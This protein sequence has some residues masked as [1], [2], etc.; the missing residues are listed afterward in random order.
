MKKTFENWLVVSDVD[1]TLNNKFRKLQKDNLKAIQKFTDLGGHFTLA[2]GRFV[3]SLSKPYHQVPAN[4]P[5]VIINGSAIY[6]YNAKKTIWR[7]EI[8]EAGRHLTVE[9]MKKFPNIDVG[10]FFDDYLY[11][12]RDGIK[13]RFQM[14]F[15]HVESEVTDIDKVPE[16][17]WCKVVFWEYP[18]NLT[19]FIRYVKTELKDNTDV[20]FMQTSP[21]SFE[22]VEGGIHK[23]VGVMKLAEQLGIEPSHVAAIGD[24]YNDYDMLKTV[25]LAA[26][27]GQAPKAIQEL[28]Q[29]KACHCNKG[30]VADFLEYIMA[31]EE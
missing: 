7:Q 10:I 16:H 30:C 19:K 18:W 1:G 24:Y 15:D 6:D 17:G 26:C 14:H 22:M 29:Y 4:A 23:G 9:L 11:I 21:W 25:P 2:S 31:L 8:T 28:C 27:A 13:V 12:V 20:N 5:A 3:S